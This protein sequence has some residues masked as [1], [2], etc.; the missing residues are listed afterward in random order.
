LPFGCFYGNGNDPLPF[1]SASHFVEEHS[2]ADAAQPYQDSA[3][4]MAAISDAVESYGN[5][6]QHSLTARKLGRSAA[7]AR[8][9]GISAR[10]H[11]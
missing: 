2:F 8:R 10:V 5:A 7:C 11:I 1:S 6:F 9:E 3:L 4:G